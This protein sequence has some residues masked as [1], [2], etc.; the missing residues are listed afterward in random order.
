ME[1]THRAIR[2]VLAD[3]ES[4]HPAPLAVNVE[5]AGVPMEIRTRYQTNVDFFR[6]FRTERP[7]ALTL[8][9][10]LRDIRRAYEAFLAAV[11]P[12]ETAPGYCFWFLE[13]AAIHRLAAEALAARDVLLFHGSAL[14]LDGQAYLFAAPSGTGKSTHA[15]LWRER[16]GPRCVM[17][18]DDKPLLRFTEEGV[19]VCGSP[20]MGKHGLGGNISAPL[21][22][23]A[24][25]VR[26]PETEVRPMTGPEA[27]KL[28]LEQSF[29][30]DDPAL[31]RA[32][33]ALR[34]SLAARVPFYRL[35]CNLAP[36]AAELAA[37]GLGALD[38]R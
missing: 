25:I 28:A 3:P 37:A 6:D 26:A 20:W 30:P 13:N 24:R 8:I 19:R 33:L 2:A 36:E 34:L 7:P 10:T 1:L 38:P 12:G 11:P 35:A 9:P 15:R 4:D 18:N 29:R 23:V 27:V 5:L 16:F 17:I 32:T 14:A 21:R 31:A 22:A